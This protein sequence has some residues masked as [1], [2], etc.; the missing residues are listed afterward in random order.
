[1]SFGLF[2]VHNF[3]IKGSLFDGSP[4][5]ANNAL[6]NKQYVLDAVAAGGG[7]WFASVLT[8]QDAPPST[9][10]TGDRYLVGASGS[11]AWASLSN[12]IVEWNGSAWDS[13]SP[14][15]GAPTA[16]AHVFIE[17]GSSNP[18]N[19]MIYRTSPSAGWVVA[20]NATGA[21]LKS[22]N[23]S[24]LDSASSARSNLGL[25]SLATQSSVD[26]GSDVSGTLPIS[27]GGTG[28]SSA[29]M[30]GLITA[31]DASAARTV[32]GAG[33]I[34]TQDSDAVSITGG[35]IT[36]ITDLA[37]ADGGTGASDAVGAR[38]N[39]G[40]QAQNELLDD[41]AGLT[42][43]DGTF[44]VGDANGDIVAES[45]ATARTSLGLGTAAVEDTGVAAGDIIKLDDAL[46]QNE[47]LG[48]VSIPVLVFS[49]N[50]NFNY[51]YTG[52]SWSATGTY[53][54]V[55]GAIL[56]IDSSSN[57]WKVSVTSGYTS[58]LASGDTVS[59]SGYSF[60]YSSTSNS[61]ENKG[62]DAGDLES[63]IGPAGTASSSTSVNSSNKGV[64]AFDSA[65]FTASSGFISLDT[66]IAAG[67]LTK[68]VGAL[69]SDDLVKA[70]SWTAVSTGYAISSNAI[71]T[72]AR[73]I[74]T[75]T[76]VSGVVAGQVFDGGGYQFEIQSISSDG[77]GTPTYTITVAD[78][79]SNLQFLYNGVSFSIA[80]GDGFVS[81][82]AYGNAANQ[83]LATG[84]GS[85][86]QGKM[87]KVS[88][89]A[90][91]AADSLLA[92]NS[93]G[94]IIAGTA[95]EQGTVTSI[96]LADDDG[97]T[98]TAITT[99]GSIAVV[100]DGTILTTNVNGSN[101]LEI[102]VATASTTAEGV[103]KK[104]S[105]TTVSGD[106]VFVG[107]D[108]AVSSSSFDSG[109]MP[110][111]NAD[112]EI[113]FSSGTGFYKNAGSTGSFVTPTGYDLDGPL[114]KSSTGLL[115]GTDSLPSA[116]SSLE[117]AYIYDL[118]SISSDVSL[119]LPT[120]IAAAERGATVTFKVQGLASGYKIR[121]NGG[122]VT[123]GG[124]MT[125]DGADYVDLDQARQSV[126]L[127]LSAV[128]VSDSESSDALCW[129]IL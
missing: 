116:I 107:F 84:V 117:G 128:M 88:A 76:N 115:N 53:G 73:T 35:S 51:L 13:T 96:S 120:S 20:A 90:S 108:S 52:A 113:T 63:I 72:S 80:G 28:S 62:L 129:S 87:L 23:L 26:L 17:G 101:Q 5:T 11:G 1:M 78:P 27:S 70:V 56:S 86:A 92:I 93:A 79:S 105:S 55:S 3:D 60:S 104:A 69:S 121:I 81:A 125:I 57:S 16:G 29:P 25:G 127:H 18:G 111:I 103:A 58:Y 66:G 124:R 97:D 32:I 98:T 99:S 95:G 74:K 47:V 114:V 48:R 45:G 65:F 40:A 49:G 68:L 109:L 122:T 38:S 14:D 6:A 83:T 123:G 119:N 33:T 4:A 82:G 46:D 106:N 21:L 31:A 110:L 112:G 100:G 10:S 59:A 75:Q 43:A 37:V 41:I 94:E 8:Q 118:G 77:A 36:G 7:E 24:D 19:T 34:A 64:A 9:P 85:S 71:D 126:T 12:N 54:T 44:L 91:L 39:L 67:D 50:T 61:V 102:A 89:S 22:N 15:T 30:V 2:G 42:I